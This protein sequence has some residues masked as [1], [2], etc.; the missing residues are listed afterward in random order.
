MFDGL[1]VNC[2]C[3]FLFK[4]AALGIG[5]GVGIA[6]GLIFSAIIVAIYVW[7][8]RRGW[9]GLVKKGSVSHLCQFLSKIGMV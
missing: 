6:G 2:L 5:L 9:P 8:R 4:D 7:A 1:L 3:C